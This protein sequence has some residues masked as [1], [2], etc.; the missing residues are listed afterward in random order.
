[1]ITDPKPIIILGDFNFTKM[2]SHKVK[3]KLPSNEDAHSLANKFADFFVEK[4][5]ILRND[6]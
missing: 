2:L 3:N 4:I 6:L 1:M 5:Q